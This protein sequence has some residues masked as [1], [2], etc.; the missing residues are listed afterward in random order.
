MGQPRQEEWVARTRFFLPGAVFWCV[1][2]LFDYLV[3]PRTSADLARRLSMEW[4]QRLY[5]S[6]RTMYRRYIFGI[7]ALFGHIFVAHCRDLLQFFPTKN[8]REESLVRTNLENLQA[9]VSTAVE[10]RHESLTAADP[11][12]K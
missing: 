12:P 3:G 2:G 6:P 5:H 10:T 1:G 8:H 7:P 11:V 4:L 9:R